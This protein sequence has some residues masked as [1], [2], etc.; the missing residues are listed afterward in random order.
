MTLLDIHQYLMDIQARIGSGVKLSLAVE[1]DCLILHAYFE[2]RNYNV[3]HVFTVDDLRRGKDA[4]F[5]GLFIAQ[6]QHAIEPITCKVFDTIEY[7]ESTLPIEKCLVWVEQKRHRYGPLTMVKTCAGIEF[8]N[9]DGKILD[10]SP[11]YP[12]E[13]TIAAVHKLFK[14]VK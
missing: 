4:W 8:H 2:H 5:I 7:R 3:Q 12:S 9:V 1:R 10:I 11:M 14:E 13:E 6:C